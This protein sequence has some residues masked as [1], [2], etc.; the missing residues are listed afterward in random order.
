MA[1]LPPHLQ[2]QFDEMTMAE[3]MAIL[4]M[5]LGEDQTAYVFSFLDQESITEISK[6]IAMSK[7]TDKQIAMAVLE[8]FYVI[9]QSNQYITSG[10][11]V[12]QRDIY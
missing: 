4:L 8:E 12:C 5:Q 10:V 2:V 9:L 1:K 6:Y 7:S 3:R 11:K